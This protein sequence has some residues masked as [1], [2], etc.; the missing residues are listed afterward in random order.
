MIEFHRERKSGGRK[1]V[2]AL[3]EAQLRMARSGLHPFYWAS[4]IA[5]GSAD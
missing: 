4:F 3:R 5:I 2:D 1:T